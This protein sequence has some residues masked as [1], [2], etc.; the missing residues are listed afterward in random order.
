MVSL[1]LFVFSAHGMYIHEAACK[2]DIY[3]SDYLYALHDAKHPEVS[4]IS[5]TLTPIRPE[6]TN[7]IWNS[8]GRVLLA[9][10]NKLSDFK[11]TPGTAFELFEETWFTVAPELQDWCNNYNGETLEIRIRQALGLPPV[12]DFDGVI[13][14]WVFPQDIFRPCPDPDISD[15]QCQINIPILGKSQ[16]YSE[17]IPPW[18]CPADNETFTQYSG[19]FVTV[20]EDHFRWMCNYWRVSYLQQEVFENFPWTGLGYTYDWGDLDDPVGFSEF[21]APEGTRVIMKSKTKLQ[22]YCNY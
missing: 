10:Y 22:E 14:V 6:N 17:D 9:T 1:L 2:N 5:T 21:V 19:K 20:S 18:Y 4:E 16:E 11:Y 15:R 3:C 12:V 13:E 7:L 8:E